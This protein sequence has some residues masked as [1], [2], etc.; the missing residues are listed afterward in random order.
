MPVKRITGNIEGDVFGQPY[1]QISLWH[2]DCAAIMAMDHGDRATPVTLAGNPPVA[3]AEIDL[4]LANRFAGQRGAF[5]ILSDSLFGFD[6]CQSIEETG[7]EKDTIV[8]D[9]RRA[10]CEGRVGGFI[11]QR[12][13][14]ND[15]P[16]W[17][18]IGDRE[19]VIALIM[20]RTPE[21]RACAVIHQDEIRDID[22]KDLRRIQRM[23][24][25]NAGIEALFV[26][27]VDR[28][29]GSAHSPAFITKGRECGVMRRSRFCEGVIGRDGHEARAEQRVR[30]RGVN[31]QLRFAAGCC[32]RIE[33]EAHHQ[34]F[35]AA[36]PV[37][38]HEAH[39]LGPAREM[40]ERG[41]Q[42]IGVI[43]D[44][45]KPLRQLPLLDQRA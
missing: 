33:S 3:Q 5:Q 41:Q 38:L 16:D 18:V 36:N 2:R 10:A 25:P 37:G 44:F 23:L 20:R 43:R 31:F 22:R 29:L 17:Q 39:L 13:W 40:I 30:P 8:H 12:G 28:C 45:Q 24:G 32:G 7:V 14:P 4:A 26:C 15:R 1:R 42:I 21:N 19:V 9:R 34:S 35:G 11:S 27:C 6:D